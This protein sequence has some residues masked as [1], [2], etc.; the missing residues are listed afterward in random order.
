VLEFGFLTLP[1]RA[2]P[3]IDTRPG[4]VEDTMTHLGVAV[5]EYLGQILPEPS[6]PRRCSVASEAS[7]RAKN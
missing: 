3:A 5:G 1:G 7:V 4:E 6:L 2:E